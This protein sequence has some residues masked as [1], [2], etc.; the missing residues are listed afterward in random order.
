[1]P[2]KKP[3]AT[4]GGRLTQLRKER[5]WTRQ[6]VYDLIRDRYNEGIPVPTLEKWENDRNEPTGTALTRL[7]ILYGVTL[8]YLFLLVND[9]RGHRELTQQHHT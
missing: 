1:M 4:I 6:D 7:A 8:D 5:G 9:R 2:T 3:P